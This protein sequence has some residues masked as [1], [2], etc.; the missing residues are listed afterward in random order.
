MFV[1][2]L[3]AD[4]VNNLE[5][6]HLSKLIKFMC[7]KSSKYGLMCMGGMWQKE[8]DGGKEV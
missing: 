6:M 5:D 8:L 1:K 4:W 2:G 7:V 3:P